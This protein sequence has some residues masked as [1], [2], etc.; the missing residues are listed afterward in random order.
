MSLSIYQDIDIYTQKK[1]RTLKMNQAEYCTDMDWIMCLE[2]K[3]RHLAQTGKVQL[4]E[5][6]LDQ[7]W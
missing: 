4:M 6:Q 1:L 5:S 7:D 2:Q 3:G